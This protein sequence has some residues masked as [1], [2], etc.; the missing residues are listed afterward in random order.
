M[1]KKIIQEPIVE[2]R[3]DI[4]NRLIEDYFSNEIYIRQ[5]IDKYI[6]RD[7]TLTINSYL[8]DYSSDSQ[9]N[10]KDEHICKFCKIKICEKALNTLKGNEKWDSM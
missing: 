5:E 7:I 3:C 1:S 9:I 4:C 8:N 6:D 2:I 10:K